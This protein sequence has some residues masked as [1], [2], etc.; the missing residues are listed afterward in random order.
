MTVGITLLDSVIVV[1]FFTL[2]RS[3]RFNVKGA[4]DNNIREDDACGVTWGLSV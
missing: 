3:I 1:G 2:V 4:G